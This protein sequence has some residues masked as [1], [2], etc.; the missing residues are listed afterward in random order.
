MPTAKVNGVEL[1]YEDQGNGFPVVFGH[2]LCFDGDMFSHQV[3]ALSSR[4]RTITV[5]FRGHGR[6]QSLDQP[7]TL[8]D[9]TEDLYRLLQHLGISQAHF[10][11]LSMGGMTAMRLALAQPEMV[12]S[13]VLL[14]TSAD[15]EEPGKVASYE[16]AAQTTRDHGPDLVIDAILPVF[17]SSSYL[18]GR[19]EE[20]AAMKQKIIERI[21]PVGV[22]HATLAVT[23]RRSII[24]EIDRIKVP[25]LI[26]VGDQDIATVPEKSQRI[27]E[28]IAGSQLVVIPNAGHMSAI[29]QPELVTS[30]IERFLSA[31][32]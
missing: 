11:G 7:Y 3:Q 31:I 26:L 4:Y 14:D 19:P 16:M 5:D 2:G 30:E 1:Y 24:E 10:V 22:Y 32:D 15:G 9:N 23:R 21:H 25:T 18:N 6:S 17:F 8:E 27:H 20:A 12:K 28:R 29:E 13:L